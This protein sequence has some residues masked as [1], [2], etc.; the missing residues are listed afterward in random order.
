MG[1]EPT[2]PLRVQ[3]FSRPARSTTPALFLLVRWLLYQPLPIHHSMLSA[4]TDIYANLPVSFLYIK[5]KI[6]NCKVI[7]IKNIMLRN[8]NLLNPFVSKV[9]LDLRL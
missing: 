6:L 7:F 9:L 2:E 4:T 5:L 3:R 1:F 8:V